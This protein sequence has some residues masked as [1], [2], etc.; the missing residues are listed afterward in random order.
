MPDELCLNREGS[1]RFFHFL[2]TRRAQEL[3]KFHRHDVVYQL[4]LLIMSTPPA[5]GECHA[6]MIK[7]LEGL[8]G[9]LVIKD[10]M[11]MDVR[12][13]SGI[14]AEQPKPM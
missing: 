4:L 12:H 14:C 8:K 7:I 6:A 10:D 3:F 2:L 9:V 5:S 1:D 11:D 13:D